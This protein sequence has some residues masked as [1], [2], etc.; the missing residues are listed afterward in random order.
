MKLG[1]ALATAG[2]VVGIIVGL[3]SHN[4]AVFFSPARTPVIGARLAPK[5]KFGE[6]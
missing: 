1:R 2:T 5:L 6:P 3:M 4:L